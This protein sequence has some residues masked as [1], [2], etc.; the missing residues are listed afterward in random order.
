MVVGSGFVGLKVVRL[1]V[2]VVVCVCVCGCLAVAGRAG[3]GRRAVVCVGVLVC[4]CVG[5][6][7][8]RCVGALCIVVVHSFVRWLVSE[9]KSITY[10]PTYLP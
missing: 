3:G 9:P 4:W 6:V 2:C 1:C 8:C 5:V 10:L 7:S